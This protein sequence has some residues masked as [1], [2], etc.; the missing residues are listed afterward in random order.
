MF[1]DLIV[2]FIEFSEWSYCRPSHFMRSEGS[3]IPL[4]SGER[5][6][7][8]SQ[9]NPFQRNHIYPTTLSVPLELI[10]DLSSQ[11]LGFFFFFFGGTGV[12]TKGFVF[13]KQ[14]LYCF[15]HTSSPFCSG[16]FG[17]GV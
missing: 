1:T 14:A 5:R 11:F 8:N 16:Y 17:T 13:A 15:S 4:I 2:W 12:L 7:W 3:S 6:I 9:Q 10:F